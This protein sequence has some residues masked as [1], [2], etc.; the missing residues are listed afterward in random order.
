MLRDLVQRVEAATPGG[1]DRAVDALRALAVAG[2]VAGHWLVTAPVADSG[3]LRVTSPLKYMPQLAPASWLLQTMAVFFFVGGRVAVESH[4][5]ARARGEGHGRWAAARMARLFRPV[6]PLV[7]VWTAAAVAMLAW[8][9][10]PGTVYALVKLVWSP[11][12][13]LLVFAALT[14]AT[15]LAAR[16][17][18]A[19]PL[20]AVAL[21]DLVRFGLDGPS[22]AGWLNVGT[23]W[24]VPYCLGALW[25]RGRLD[26]RL[27]GWAL[28]LGGA[29]ATAALVLWAGYP[30]SMV[31]VPGAPVSN[32]SPPTVAAVAFGLAQC[33]A[34]L[35][36]SG[37][38][39]RVLRRPA[40][41]APVALVNV[42]A[43][44]LF[45][46]HQ[47]AMIAVTAAALRL[48]GGALPGL[49]TVPGDP[50]WVAA[51]LAWLP[52]FAAA[53]AVCWAV[54]RHHETRRPHG[55]ERPLRGTRRERR[56]GGSA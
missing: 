38:L 16:L 33:G 14:A 15:P 30:A 9:A 45:L 31:G 51:R 23:G 27:T 50:G 2:V 7:G 25:A 43:M 37:P 29:A 36:L 47:T 26:G 18:P 54:F 12:W 32:Q 11:M 55:A 41:W 48:A 42:S 35:V 13:F 6:V 8:G 52:A 3:V 4:G 17:H 44:T 1:R 46:W 24:L 40:V 10:D 39:R 53:L 49:H 34:A 28:L 22:W 20:A 56:A 19:W 5:R 21:A